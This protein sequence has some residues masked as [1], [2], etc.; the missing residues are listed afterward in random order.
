MKQLVFICNALDDVTR[1]ERGIVT[2]SPAASRKIFLL[3]RAM[4]KVGVRPLVLSSG[5]GR[6]DGSGR[7]FDAKVKRV[8]GLIV[9]YLPFFHIKIFSELLTLFSS[10]PILLYLHRKKAI[11]TIVFYN[12]MIAY[13]PQLFFAKMLGINTV[14]DLEDGEIELVTYSL[15]SIKS[16]V[17]RFLYDAFCSG[18]ALLACQ[19]LEKSTKLRPTQCC[20]GVSDIA[21][22]TVSWDS[23]NINV[24]FGGTVSYDT[25]AAVL[26]DAINLLREESSDWSSKIS[27]YITGKGDCLERFK[28][29]EADT[30]KPKVIVYGRTTDDEYREILSNT[31]VGLALKPNYGEL[32]NTTFPSKV[33]EFASLGI[34]VVSTDISDVRKVLANGAIYLDIDDP[35]LL[36][37]KLRWIVENP[38]ASKALSIS[39]MRAFYEI[40]SPERV[41]A[42]LVNFLF[43]SPVG[44]LG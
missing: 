29:L 30:R 17:L 31:H 44:G 10:V 7:Y 18:G 1:L 11:N 12:R 36:I 35:K 25:G 3:C 41:G 16:H 28:L 26:I 42:R 4:K 37:E 9:V 20:Y 38:N 34:L 40:C 6:Q 24:L 8:N 43:K 39:G 32:A 13:L 15:S 14:L 21:N 33:I 27:F 2:D 19:A 22:R 23:S 5:R